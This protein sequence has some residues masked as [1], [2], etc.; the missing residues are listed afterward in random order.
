MYSTALCCSRLLWMPTSAEMSCN[1]TVTF[2][3]QLEIQRQTEQHKQRQ[4]TASVIMNEIPGRTRL[5]TSPHRVLS[6]SCNIWNDVARSCCTLCVSSTVPCEHVFLCVRAFALWK[7][8]KRE[9]ERACLLV[10]VRH[11]FK[12]S[13]YW[14]GKEWRKAGAEEQATPGGKRERERE[15]R[16]ATGEWKSF[17]YFCRLLRHRRGIN[18]SQGLRVAI[19]RQ[20]HPPTPFFF[21]LLFVYIT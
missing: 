17:C 21:F 14:N 2:Y 20:Q 9:M 3:I 5:K 15:S 19:S 12:L 1:E 4:K 11:C 8:E 13:S 7:R 18:L 16:E 6:A 10:H